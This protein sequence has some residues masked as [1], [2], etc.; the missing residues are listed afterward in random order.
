MGAMLAIVL[1]SNKKK[2]RCDHP[3]EWMVHAKHGGGIRM[4]LVS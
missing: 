3:N 4:F 1:V 2:D